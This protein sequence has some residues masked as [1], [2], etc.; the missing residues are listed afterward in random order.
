VRVTA[1]EEGKTAQVGPNQL[2]NHGSPRPLPMRVDA[3]TKHGHLGC[4]KKCP[5]VGNCDWA[6]KSCSS[7][8]QSMSFVLL[9][10]EIPPSAARATMRAPIEQTQLPSLASQTTQCLVCANLS[11]MPAR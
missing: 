9:F 1:L 6:C 7:A 4:S 10:G 2:L 5:Q 3:L 11:R 8:L